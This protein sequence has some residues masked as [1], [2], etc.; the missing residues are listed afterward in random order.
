MNRRRKEKREEKEIAEKNEKI[1]VRP[2][3]ARILLRCTDEEDL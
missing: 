1:D 3:R 2:T